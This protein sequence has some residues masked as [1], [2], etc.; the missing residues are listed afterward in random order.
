LYDQAVQEQEN[1]LQLA[2]QAQEQ[3]AA[4]P[5]PPGQPPLPPANPPMLTPLPPEPFDLPRAIEERI[6]VLWLEMLQV[7]EPEEYV[8]SQ[9]KPPTPEQMLCLYLKY[10]A[11][12]EAYRMYGEQKKQQAMEGIAKLSAPGGA[13][14][15]A[16]M[17]PTPG[18]TGAEGVPTPSTGA[19]GMPAANQQGQQMPTGQLG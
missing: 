1:A 9:D 14:T 8:F 7:E 3:Q 18:D 5:V 10:C 4:L 17:E 16:G 6:Y 15:A 12:V 11:L 19:G 13:S 2:K